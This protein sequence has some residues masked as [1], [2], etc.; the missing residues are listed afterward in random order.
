MT[1]GKLERSVKEERWLIKDYLML[2]D[3]KPGYGVGYTFNRWRRGLN[4][5][6][7]INNDFKNLGRLISWASIFALNGFLLVGGK[8]L[9][10]Y[11]INY[12]N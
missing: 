10:K 1:K 4:Q 9:I 6:D 11:T 12:I 8:Y 7:L 3:L 5:N 2:K